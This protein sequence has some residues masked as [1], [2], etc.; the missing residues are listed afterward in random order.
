MSRQRLIEDR[1]AKDHLC[2]TLLHPVGVAAILAQFGYP[3]DL[4]ITALVHDVMEGLNLQGYVAAIE[5][6]LPTDALGESIALAFL[7]LCR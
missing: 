2:H 6:Y 1:F 3:V 4:L 7:W 5:H